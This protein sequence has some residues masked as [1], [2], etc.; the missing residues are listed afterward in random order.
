MNVLHWHIVDQQSFSFQSEV[1]PSFPDKGGYTQF[2]HVYSIAEIKDLIEYARL[3]GI[4]I[5]P[6]FDT[7]GHTKAWGPGGGPDFLT[8]C[9][10]DYGEFNG[11][12]G[13]IDPSKPENFK[14]I[15]ELI[16]EVKQ[17]GYRLRFFYKKPAYKKLGLFKKQKC[18]IIIYGKKS[19]P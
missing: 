12:Y 1:L 4:R 9:A 13:P 11:E 6:E 2:N 14:I 3:R 17:L 19:Y 8:K 16:K 18:Y 10:N 5:I 15:G 7:P